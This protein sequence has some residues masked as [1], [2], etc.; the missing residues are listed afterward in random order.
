MITT[1]IQDRSPKSQPQD[2]TVAKVRRRPPP[3]RGQ[4]IAGVGCSVLAL[5]LVLIIPKGLWPTGLLFAVAPTLLGAAYLRNAA[6]RFYGEH[7]EARA[8]AAV[9][10]K[11]PADWDIA[12]RVPVGHGDV[13]LRVLTTERLYAVEIKSQRRVTLAS[14]LFGRERILV[15]GRRFPHHDPL[16]QAKTAGLRC[17]AESSVKV[18]SVLWFPE[19]DTAMVK[20]LRCGVLLVFGKP[21]LLITALK[22]AR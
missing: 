7:V 11:A 2:A 13:D 6:R 1:S 10:R 9:R 5:F 19:A 12:D 16:E 21:R 20:R 3:W 18:I 17:R 8:I 14:P 22:K 15:S 4:L